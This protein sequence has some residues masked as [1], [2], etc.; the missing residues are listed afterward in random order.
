MTAVTFRRSRRP[1]PSEIDP[2]Y[3]FR[4]APKEIESSP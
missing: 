4:P 3:R 2:K 1:N